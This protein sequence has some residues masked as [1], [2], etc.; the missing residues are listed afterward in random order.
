MATVRMLGGPA[1][2]K[3]ASLDRVPVAGD[4]IRLTKEITLK[5]ERV[6]LIPDH[7]WAADI[8][9]VGVSEQDSFAALG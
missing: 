5:V 6:G 8:I 4:F 3:T 9:V 7:D 1:H 2:G